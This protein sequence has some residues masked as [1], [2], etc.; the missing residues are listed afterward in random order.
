MVNVDEMFETVD[1]VLKCDTLLIALQHLLI[2]ATKESDLDLLYRLDWLGV[3]PRVYNSRV[4]QN[5]RNIPSTLVVGSSYIQSIA[6]QRLCLSVHPSLDA[7]KH[8]FLVLNISGVACETRKEWERR[9]ASFYM[10]NRG[11]DLDILRY[12]IDNHGADV[13]EPCKH[14]LD[15]E[16]EF[17]ALQA[18]CFYGP[19][20]LSLQELANRL[21]FLLEHGADINKAG[22]EDSDLASPLRLAIHAMAPFAFVRKLIEAGADVNMIQQTSTRYNSPITYSIMVSSYSDR[23]KIDLFLLFADHG[24][25]AEHFLYEHPDRHDLPNKTPVEFVVRYYDGISISL[26]EK[27]LQKML[28][29]DN[30]SSFFCRWAM[31]TNGEDKRKR[32]I[33]ENFL[34]RKAAQIKRKLK[35][36][37]RVDLLE[38]IAGHD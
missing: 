13:N 34:K 25:K 24:V 6:F 36:A 21:S 14:L 33:G 23:G 27:R 18:L 3:Y 31:L 32:L 8:F 35:E 2:Q 16:T 17:T 9:T 20:D 5:E 12:L 29:I 37:A 11:F 4:M 15:N 1:D 30:V 28:G 10:C 38:V 26:L 19:K 7:V 22:R